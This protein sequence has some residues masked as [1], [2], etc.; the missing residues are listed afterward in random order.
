MPCEANLL[1]GT[2]GGRSDCERLDKAAAPGK[3]LSL[4]IELIETLDELAIADRL[5]CAS[6]HHRMARPPCIAQ[7]GNG[8]QSLLKVGLTTGA[9]AR[10]RDEHPGAASPLVL[11]PSV[12]QEALPRAES[13]MAAALETNEL[14]GPSRRSSIA[15][16]HILLIANRDREEESFDDRRPVR[17]IALHQTSPARR[18]GRGRWQ[19]GDRVDRAVQLVEIGKKGRDPIEPPTSG[20]RLQQGQQR[21][22]RPA[23]DASRIQKAQPRCQAIDGRGADDDPRTMICHVRLPKIQLARNTAHDAHVRF[24]D[25]CI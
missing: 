3:L 4:A 7:V 22:R 2:R 25:E 21:L 8:S 14:L 16:L 5:E 18:V 23:R 15:R 6:E 11:D 17:G 13:R 9:N 1:S 24:D 20:A 19:V 12:L 10:R